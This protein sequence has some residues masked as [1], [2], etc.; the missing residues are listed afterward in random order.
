MTPINTNDSFF[1]IDFS[2]NQ[3][4]A[5]AETIAKASALTDVILA[6]DLYLLSKSSL[7]DFLW[8]LDDLT[9]RANELCKSLKLIPLS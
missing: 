9:Y 1:T 6:A 3:Y 8:I 2:L 7:Y 5:L 4:D